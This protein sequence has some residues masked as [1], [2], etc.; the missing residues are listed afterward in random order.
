MSIKFPLIENTYDQTDID[1]MVNVLRSDKLTMGN[2]VKQFEKEFS[3]YIG[4]NYSI[5]VNSGSSANLLAM[6]VA[7]NYMRKNKL[8]S[9]DKIIVPNICWSTSIW[10]LIQ[11]GLKPVFV[12]VDSNT[13]NIDINELKKIITSDIKGIMV[14]HILGNCTNMNDIMNIV[15]DNNLFLIED[16]CESLGSTY[17]GKKLGTFGDFGTYSFYYSHHITTIEGG[18]IVCNNKEDYELLKCL[19]SHGWIRQLDDKE[20]YIKDNPNVDP[21][22]LFVNLG[23]NLR[24]METQGAMG[25]NQL[26]KLDLKNNNRVINHN[27]ILDKLLN[28][29]RNLEIF[30]SPKKQ[31]NSEPAWFS[32]TIILGE[33]YVKHYKSFLEYLTMSGVENRPIVTGNFARQPVFKYLDIDINPESFKGAE[34]LHNRGFFIGLSCEIM[35]NN[36]ID[37]LVNIFYNYRYNI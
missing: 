9:G 32:L 37:E 11:M 28:D 20:K 19:R 23:Y 31:I 1:V 16:T 2:K 35:D 24:P 13:M 4:S 25:L 15:N 27:R 7:V 14:V 10:P 5:M 21:R 6:S 12:D 29:S 36:K 34:I 8:N 17:N 30:N 18:M 33:K 26:K 3:K 22:F